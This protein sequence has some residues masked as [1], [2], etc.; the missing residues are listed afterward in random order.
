M[1]LVD[2][3]FFPSRLLAN[4]HVQ[5]ILPAILPRRVSVAFTRERLELPDGDFVDLDLA[6]PDAQRVVVI[7]HG[8]E[9][10]SADSYV[11]GTAALFANAGWRVV[12][13]NYRG[14]SGEPNRLP[15]S[16][17]SGDTPDLGRV[18]DWA[19][20]R[21]Q[22]VAL[23]G[24]SLGGNLTLK[25]VGER[26][27]TSAVLGAVAIS[28]PVDLADSAR[29]L[30]GEASNRFYLG[31]LIRR[32]EHKIRD[33]AV[34]FPDH[35]RVEDLVGVRGFAELDGRFTAPLHG[36]RDADDYWTQSSARPFIPAI[37]VPALLINALDDPFLAGGCF[38]V[39]EAERS[40]VFHLETPA[41][42]GHLGFVENLTAK[43]PWAERRA[44]AFLEGIPEL[45]PDRPSRSA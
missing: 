18:I 17:H 16:Y 27:E 15:R 40:E 8:L 25:F 29:K 38:P 2:S 42:G 30:D 10:S 44:L 34:R 1:P 43:F 33:K 7:S 35:L 23:I 5:T 9:G 26:S 45:R 32:L 21:G 36:F 6:G 31:R 39:A 12:A 19:S 3:E 4:P 20:A 37:R 22:R 11:R 13:W 14:C 41:H 24:F 28:A